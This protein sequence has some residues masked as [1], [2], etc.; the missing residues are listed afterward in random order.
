MKYLIAL[1]AGL[2][3]GAVLF[4]AGMMYNPWIGK[5]GLSPVS[6]TDSQ[7]ITL[8]YSAVPSTNIVFT[9][10]GESRVDPF[11]DKVLQLWEASV[12]QTTAM[13]TVLNDARSQFAGIGIKIS[14]LS[15]KTRLLSG[16]AIVDSVWYVYLPGRGSF[17]VEQSENY[18]TYLRDIVFPSYRGSANSWKG[19][20]LSDI[21]VGPGALGTAKV[22][23]GSGE[24]EN[25]EMDAVESLSVKAWSAEEG[26]ISAEGRLTIELPR[27]TVAEAE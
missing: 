7:I 27:V 17:F 20:W 11:P 18:W 1:T 14:S 6:V 16:D 24:F 13:A 10:N 25:F 4:V 5:Q 9:N 8:S 2:I 19:T 22:T 23:G 26:P 3:V 12:R 15:E 21:S